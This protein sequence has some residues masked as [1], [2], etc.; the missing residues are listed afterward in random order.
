MDAGFL[1]PRMVGMVWLT[2]LASVAAAGAIGYALYRLFRVE[3]PGTARQ[4]G[5]QWFAYFL[6]LASATNLPRFFRHQD[7]DSFVPWFFTVLVLGPLVYLAG[8]GYAKFKALRAQ[9]DVDKERNARL[10]E[11]VWSEIKLKRIDQVLWT[12][13]FAECDGDQDKA[14]ARYIKERVRQLR[15]KG[16]T[17]PAPVPETSTVPRLVAPRPR[18]ETPVLSPRAGWLLLSVVLASAALWL[19]WVTLSKPP[20]RQGNEVAQAPSTGRGNLPVDSWGKQAQELNPDFSIKE[21]TQGRP[22]DWAEWNAVVGKNFADTIKP[23]TAPL[24]RPTEV[25]PL[26]LLRDFTQTAKGLGYNPKQVS[27]MFPQW[28]A[29]VRSRDLSQEDPLGLLRDFTR[30]A[31]GLGYN[32]DQA[33]EIFTQWLATAQ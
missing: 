27:Q 31:R 30:S 19:G 13:V 28:M 11:V 9:R 17:N 21:P 6:F 18:A 20:H 8:W 22:A 24:P 4:H 12:R 14:K 23:H 1:S 2:G 7:A 5:R 29:V 25:D 26:R 3:N 15:E 32:P 16:K 10:Y 33:A